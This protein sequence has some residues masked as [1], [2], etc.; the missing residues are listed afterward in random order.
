[1]NP[2]IEVEKMECCDCKKGIVCSSRRQLMSSEND[3]A[4]RR[5]T[6]NNPDAYAKIVGGI[7]KVLA[8]NCPYY[9]VEK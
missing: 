2:Y 8:E 1:M 4:I 3:K 9:E 5:L 6:S 7:R